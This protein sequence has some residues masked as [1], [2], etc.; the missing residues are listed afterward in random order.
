MGFAIY[1][2]STQPVDA[3]VADAIC[4][5]ATRLIAG[6]TWLSCEPVGFHLDEG[7]GRLVGHSKPNFTPDPDDAASAA[8]EGLPDGTIADVVQ[9]L[10]ALSKDF[11]IDWE[12]SHDY[13]PGPIGFIRAGVCEGKL[14]D[15]LDAI[16][17][18]GDVLREVG[19][20]DDPDDDPN[21]DGP[22]ILPFQPKST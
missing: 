10:C 11:S 20:E 13:D 7:S 4:E 16:A 8:Q 19:D 5:A 14:Y 3:D 6:C 12:F 2:R 17:G 22:A 15:Q 18:L 1:Y 21:D 9:I